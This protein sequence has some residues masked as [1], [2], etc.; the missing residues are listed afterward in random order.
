MTKSGASANVGVLLVA[1]GGP[2]PSAV[3]NA[4]DRDRVFIFGIDHHIGAAHASP[5]RVPATRPVAG[6]PAP[7]DRHSRTG[8]GMTP[9]VDQ[10][11]CLVDDL[12]VRLRWTL[13][14]K[15]L[16]NLG[17]KPC[18]VGVGVDRKPRGQS[19]LLCNAG[20]KD[21]HRVRDRQPDIRQPFRRFSFESVVDA[22][23]QHGGAGGHGGD[24]HWE[25]RGRYRI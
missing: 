19:T 23:M 4:K 9:L 24:P 15:S 7:P 22:D 12:A 13:V 21:T 14:F 25:W 1:L 2:L 11:L 8:P 16:L 17:A 10:S 3:E 6:P 18:V 5:Q 20:Q